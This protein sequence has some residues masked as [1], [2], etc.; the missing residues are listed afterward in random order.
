MSDHGSTAQT[1]CPDTPKTVVGSATDI[2][3]CTNIRLLGYIIAAVWPFYDMTTNSTPSWPS[4]YNPGIEILHIEHQPPTNPRGAYLYH[5]NGMRYDILIY[6]SLIKKYRHFSIYTLLDVDVLYPSLFGLRIL[7]F[8]ELCRTT[9][10]K[11]FRRNRPCRRNGTTALQFSEAECAADQTTSQ[12]KRT[13]LQ[14]RF[15]T[16]RL[17]HIPGS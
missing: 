16:H 12:A 1:V 2:S 11:G 13:A 5:A 3:F 10:T 17:V 4:L 9:F 14:S 15:R 6:N 7:R 8:L